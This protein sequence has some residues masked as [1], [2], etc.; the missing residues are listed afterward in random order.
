MKIEKITENKIRVIVTIKDLNN[1]NTS[2]SS[3]IEKP[4]DT[5]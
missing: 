4:F 2:I 3:L 1:S 5:R